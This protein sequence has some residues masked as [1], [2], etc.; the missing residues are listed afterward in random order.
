MSDPIQVSPPSAVAVPRITPIRP[1]P[2]V[3][4]PRRSQA[5]NRGSDDYR[6]SQRKASAE[7]E[8][9][10]MISRDK[11]TRA[12]VY[13][14]VDVDSGDVLWQYP[15]EEM[16]RRSEYLRQLEDRRREEIAHEVDQRA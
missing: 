13:R 4:P 6:E 16:L 10:M 9:H 2:P 11:A 5:D 1:E 8:R 14:S 12:F 7:A 3:E 15:A